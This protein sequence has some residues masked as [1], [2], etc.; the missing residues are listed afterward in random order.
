[1]ADA[2]KKF[3][4]LTSPRVVFKFPALTKPDY[5]TKDYPNPEGSYKVSGVVDASDPAVQAFIAKLQPLYEEALAE[6][7]RKFSELK[8]DARK[9]L[10]AVQPNDLFTTLYDKETEEPTGQIEFRFKMAASGIA[11]KGTDRERKWS[12]K[13]ALFDAKG[14][15]ITGDVEI[16]GGTIGKV[17]FEARPYFVSG[18]AAAGLSLKLKAVQ[19]IEL[20][21]G[22]DRSAD[23][24][25]FSQEEGY[26][27]IEQATS[28]GFG[29]ETEG[30][31]E[32]TSSGDGD[33]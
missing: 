18:T 3:P 29:D 21:Q 31:S 24:Y 6:A 12:A 1:M 11:N 15:P 26:D 13:P 16:W 17:S 23:Q 20:R 30:G 27:H 14:K 2:R 7:E 25:G 5:G 4:M 33:F 10:K 19:V 22:G 32:D 9:K 28:N 8:I